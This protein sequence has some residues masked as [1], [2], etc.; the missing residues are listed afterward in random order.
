[1]ENQISGIYCI[2][3]IIDNKKYIGSSKDIGYRFKHHLYRL[4]NNRHTNSH[5]QNAVNKYGISNF[6]FSVLEQCSKETLIEREQ[7]YIDQEPWQM[8]Y[9]KT[10][11][12]YG[13]GS[14]AVEKPLYLLDLSGN[15]LDKFK[16]GTKLA[17]FLNRPL[18]SYTKINT[19]SIVKKQY[20]IVT[21]EF[22]EENLQLIKTWKNYSNQS[23]QRTKLH[24]LYKYKVVKDNQE[25]LFN[26]KKAL[27]TFIGISNQRINQI[28]KYLDSKGLTSYLHKKTGFSIQYVIKN[29]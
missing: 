17:K 21:I 11:I 8:L 19:S 27:S 4:N 2:T 10:R 7:F 12:A 23:V 20:R 18:L 15:I 6:T 14:D 16:S 1:M 5:L 28:F 25:T 22:Y 29:H 24:S 13:G 26:T 9:N 3:N